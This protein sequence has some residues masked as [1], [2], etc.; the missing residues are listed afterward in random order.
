M[1][2]SAGQS[3]KIQLQLVRA[4]TANPQGGNPAGVICFAEFP[5]QAQLQQLAL[6][7]QQPVTSMITWVLAEAKTHTSA[8]ALTAMIAAVDSGVSVPLA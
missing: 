5:S 4:F 1:A 6:Q 2:V 8:V 3:S 7:A